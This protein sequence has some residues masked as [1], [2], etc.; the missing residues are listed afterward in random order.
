MVLPEHQGLGAGGRLLKEGLDRADAEGVPTYL[1][2]TDA[3]SHLFVSAE[4][5]PSG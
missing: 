1:E 3:V 2:A 5:A 4:C